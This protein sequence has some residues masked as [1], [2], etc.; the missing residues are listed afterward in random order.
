MHRTH[1]RLPFE[2]LSLY[3]QAVFLGCIPQP[4]LIPILEEYISPIRLLA[5]YEHGMAGH[6]LNAGSMAEA[7]HCATVAA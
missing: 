3:R 7:S 6:V 5:A 2:I 1:G 4:P